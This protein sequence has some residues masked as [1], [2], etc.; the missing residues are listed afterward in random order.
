MEDRW[1]Q[2]SDMVNGVSFITLE[3]QDKYVKTWSEETRQFVQR[4]ENSCESEDSIIRFVQSITNGCDSNLFNKLNCIFK[5]NPLCDCTTLQK[6]SVLDEIYLDVDVI[7]SGEIRDV[8]GTTIPNH[9]LLPV[10]LHWTQPNVA[11]MI[12]IVK[13]DTEVLYR[14]DPLGPRPGVNTEQIRNA[15]RH[16]IPVITN[17]IQPIGFGV[18]RI[19]SLYALIL[20]LCDWR[21]KSGSIHYFEPMSLAAVEELNNIVREFDTR[22]RSIRIMKLQYSEAYCCY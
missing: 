22:R 19:A 17:S 21:K 16:A 15:T 1:K 2:P 5:Y 10:Y 4:I 14:V 11:H 18:C 6:Y 12:W 3:N 7:G 13:T 9:S 20:F 8:I